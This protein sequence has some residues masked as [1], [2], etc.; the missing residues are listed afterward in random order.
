LPYVKENLSPTRTERVLGKKD[1]MSTYAMQDWRPTGEQLARVER[2]TDENGKAFYMALSAH[3]ADVVY[4]ISWRQGDVMPSCSCPAYT[5]L[6]WHVKTVLFLE[7][8][9]VEQAVVEV[10]DA[11]AHL[12]AL[13][14]QEVERKAARLERDY[15]THLKG[16]LHSSLG[17]SFLK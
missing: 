8:Q 17:F 3:D 12:D 10:E 13:Q 11:L 9:A 16:S 5:A 7:Q 6:C 1:I 4:T 2:H 15:P 14:D